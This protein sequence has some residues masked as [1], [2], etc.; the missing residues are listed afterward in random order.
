MNKNLKTLTLSA[1]MPRPATAADNAL[2]APETTPDTPFDSGAGRPPIVIVRRSRLTVQ[3][4]PAVPEEPVIPAPAADAQ[5]SGE[6]AAPPSGPLV[7]RK[8]SRLVTSLQAAHAPAAPVL[9]IEPAPTAAPLPEQPKD[10]GADLMTAQSSKGKVRVLD[11]KASKPA[12]PLSAAVKPAEA[13][14][15]AP[16]AA[17]QAAAPASRAGRKPATRALENEEI[18]EWNA[19]EYAEQRV[20]KVRSSKGA[21]PKLNDAELDRH[22]KQLAALIKRGTERGYLTQ[23]EIH[24]QFPDDMDDRAAI[25]QFMQTV[26]DMG[27]AVYEQ[28]PDDAMLLL[29]ERVASDASDDEAS[30]AAATALSGEDY[31]RSTDPMRMYMR[32]MAATEL[33]TREGEIAIAR[34]I[35]DGRQEMIGAIS[36]SPAAVTELLAMAAK[37]EKGQLS[38]EEL[39]DGMVELED[40]QPAAAL[41]DEAVDIDESEE[42][43]NDELPEAEEEAGRTAEML[44]RIRTVALARFAHIADQAAIMLGG[45][46]GEARAAA[47]QSITQAMLGIRFT[48][49]TVDKLCA[50]VRLQMD[51]VRAIEKQI[52]A[53]VVDQCAMPRERFIRTFADSQTDRQWIQREVDNDYPYSAAL[54]RRMPAVH[55]LQAKLADIE[56]RA[57]LPLSELRDVSRHMLAGERR[58]AEA[59]RELTQANLR[60]VISIAKKYVNRGLQF[61]D[62]VQEGNIG[63]LR[64][65]EKYEYRRGFKFSTYATWWVRQSMSR[66]IADQART[67]RVPVHMIETINK[68]NRIIRQTVAATGEEPEV[69]TLAKKLG[70]SVERVE[71]VLRIAKEPA[72][73]DAPAG[74]DGDAMLG[75]FISDDKTLSPEASAMHM[76]MRRAISEVLE[77]L[78]PKEQKVLR[79][80]FGLD[81]GDDSTLEEIGKQLEVTRE[82]IRQIEMKAMAKLRQPNRAEKLRAFL[83]ERG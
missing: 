10:I 60:L 35:E 78:S 5:S 16:I 3:P 69:E 53:I 54:A 32:E 20:A 50:I 1:R 44:A 46:H 25:A 55:E 66:A 72:S 64:A 14:A 68:M 75:D 22:R 39:V 8:R 61:L 58:T 47:Q 6:S 24:D 80:R 42:E 12:A 30:A 37:I 36:A 21:S 40:E 49:K 29:S 31:G 81:T 76:G 52:S 65:V 56:A 73:L 82:R 51:E 17:T 7:T 38:V 74:E 9:A 59:K 48:P 62:L 43:D 23:A 19:A 45:V 77:E 4:A 83:E 67:I 11:R 33:L 13:P 15:P 41:A 63:L 71:E 27:I 28:A 79:M 70:L 34:R 18:N 57:G 2:S 26:A